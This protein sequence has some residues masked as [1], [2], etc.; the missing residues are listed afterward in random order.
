MEKNEMLQ[1][2]RIRTV[3]V[4]TQSNNRESREA[5]MTE[6]YILKPS[7]E[8]SEQHSVSDR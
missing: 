5:R 6:W 4:K 8:A 7:F 1:W 2:K 3:Q